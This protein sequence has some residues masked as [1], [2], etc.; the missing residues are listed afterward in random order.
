MT[1]VGIIFETRETDII[2]LTQLRDRVKEL[3]E[4]GLNAENLQSF[5]SANIFN[6]VENIEKFIHEGKD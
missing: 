1:T 4:I 2:R 3:L 6:L 5:Y